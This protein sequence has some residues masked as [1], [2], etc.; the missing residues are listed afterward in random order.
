MYCTLDVCLIYKVKKGNKTRD[1]ERW[2]GGK[3]RCRQHQVERRRKSPT[4]PSS[5][6]AGMMHTISFQGRCDDHRASGPWQRTDIVL[7]NHNDLYFKTGSAL[8]HLDL[9][10]IIIFHIILSNMFCHCQVA[11]KI[12]PKYTS[13]GN[14]ILLR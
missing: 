10:H 6:F 13:C 7:V 8:A 11:Y 2:K 5:K 9:L 3:R 14:I 1:R 12:H 4:H